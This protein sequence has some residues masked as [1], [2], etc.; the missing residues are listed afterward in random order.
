MLFKHNDGGRVSAGFKGSAGDCV[1]RAIAIV[2]RKPYKE[3]YSELAEEK[4][5]FV[6]NKKSKAA[7]RAARGKGLSGTTPR[8]GVAKEIYHIYLVEKIGMGWVPT[9]LLSQGCKVHLVSNELPSGK[10]IARVSKHVKAVLD[11]V[12]NDLVD[13]SLKCVYGFYCFP[14][15]QS[16]LAVGE[17]VVSQNKRLR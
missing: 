1:K 9:M 15:Y 14:E 3:I 17:E 12:I 8:N 13:C 11:R 7:K 2:T 10:I 5:C 16:Q 6:G 4:K